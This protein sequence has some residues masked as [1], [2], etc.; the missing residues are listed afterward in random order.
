MMEIGPKMISGL[1]LNFSG[2]PFRS[3][4]ILQGF[5]NSLYSQS[6]AQFNKQPVNLQALQQGQGSQNQKLQFNG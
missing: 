2:M 6:F 1:Q 3:N 4:E 5:M